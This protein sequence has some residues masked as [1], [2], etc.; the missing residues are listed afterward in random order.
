VNAP[1]VQVSGTASP[2]AVVTVND[3]ILV[4]GADGTF[5]SSVTLE[6]GPNLIE[7]I[8]SNSSGDAQTVDLTV[9]YQP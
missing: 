5:T 1:E 8:A 2:G 3:A 9:S 7:V 4:V 6:Q